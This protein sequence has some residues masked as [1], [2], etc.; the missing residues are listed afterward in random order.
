MTNTTAPKFRRIANG[1]YGTGI[2]RAACGM[3]FHYE[4]DIIEVVIDR[5]Y[6]TWY[7]REL[8]PYGHM[9]DALGE[10]FWTLRDAKEYIA[11]CPDTV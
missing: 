7:V 4:V 1:L 6:D 8:T 3:N 11:R 2:H 9:T 5:M 10:A